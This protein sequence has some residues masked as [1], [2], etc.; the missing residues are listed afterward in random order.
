MNI[1]YRLSDNFYGLVVR[2]F[3]RHGRGTVAFDDFIQACVT[4]QVKLYLILSH[5]SISVSHK[6]LTIL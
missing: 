5:Y 6:Y 2:K 4:I 3:D 1:G